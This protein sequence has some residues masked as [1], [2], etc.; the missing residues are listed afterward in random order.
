MKKQLIVS[1]VVVVLGILT[2]AISQNNIDGN[3]DTAL[4]GV[5]IDENSKLS[6]VESTYDFGNVSMVKG[7]VTHDFI[8]TN[9]SE[10]IV[11]IG[12]VWTS[13]MCTEAFLKVGNNEAG[14]FGMPGHG[15]VKSANMRIQPG[16]KFALRAE[17]DP[18]AH[19]PAGVGPI[20]R[21]VY[22]K[23]GNNEKVTVN[24]TATVTP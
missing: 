4:V 5:P 11:D 10:E 20:K 15:A 12:E 14:P 3:S 1:S 9:N 17:F 23:A 22:L 19:G 16:E 13:C 21:D 6:V 24:F 18:A 8:I 2:I 7:V